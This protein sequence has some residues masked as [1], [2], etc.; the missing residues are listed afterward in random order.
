MKTNSQKTN[1]IWMGAAIGFA[2]LVIA[3]CSESA[4]A[5]S[6]T[7]PSS[8]NAGI[9]TTSPVSPLEV[10]APDGPLTLSQ[11]G[12]T[13]KSTVQS[14]AGTDLHMSANAKY[15]SSTW[16]RYDTSMPSWNFFLSPV[17]DY[18][19]LRRSAAGSGGITWTDLIRITN[20]GNVGIGTTS[21][22]QYS[23]LHLYS[24][25]NTGTGLR[26]ENGDTG[27]RAFRLL[28]TGSANTGGAGKFHFYD[29][30]AAAFRMT[31]DSAGN[32]GIGTTSPGT[33][34]DVVNSVAAGTGTAR[35]KNT[36][37]NTQVIID[38]AASQN[39]NLRFDNN[40]S[41]VWY[42]GNSANNDRFR[43]LN[44]NANANSELFT[45]LQGGN[46]G[47]GTSTPTYKLHV[48]G[49]GRFTG[50]LT[51]DGN[52]AAKYQDVAE[53]VPAAQQLPSG[54]VVVL[55][56][57]KSNQVIQSTQSYDTRVAGVISEQPGIALGERGESKVLVATTGRVRAKVDASRGAIHIGDL[58]VTSD[59]PGVAMKSEP[60]NIGG[61]QLHR[62]GTLIGKALEPLAK[63]CGEILV[64][65][66][67]Q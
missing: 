20:T 6:N 2:L 43:L 36:N 21:P 41:P 45:I 10:Q 59:M 42:V 1:S 29:E 47:I 11:S 9:G 49:D 34:L 51:V 58:L 60:V 32:V 55:D 16:S 12:V 67:L 40:G 25:A 17:V 62:P 15:S 23:L 52:L 8:G 13:G 44:S 56:S 3:A 35:F 24:T 64:L 48:T 4:V 14:A 27:G 19:G 18:A 26:I 50:N 7:F 66:S 39:V 33:A 30:S 54:T 63:G 65:L 46:V 22:A 38:S 28:S 57:T 5:Q 37:A 31:V 61:V 53:W